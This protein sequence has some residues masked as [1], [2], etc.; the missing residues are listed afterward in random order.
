MS[1]NLTKARLLIV[2][3]DQELAIGLRDFFEDE[4]FSAQLAFDGTQALKQAREQTFDLIILDV[5]LP[6]ISGFELLRRWRHE[7]LHTP[8]LLLTAKGQEADKIEGFRSGAD[9]YVTKP[10]S[11][12]ELLERVRAILRR[13][14]PGPV[15]LYSFGNV[16]VNFTT[17]TAYKDNQP[18]SFTALEF[19]ILKYLIEHRGRSV[20]RQQLLRDVWHTREDLTTRTIDRHIASL[21]KKIEDDADNPRYIA[22]VYG[23]GYKFLG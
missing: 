1:Q 4:G 18:I 15:E 12:A 20:S 13:A 9:D 19:A 2:E 11:A 3:D 21:R 10:F 7:G 23:V 17:H 6:G 8:V 16:T 22:T 5:M 14:I